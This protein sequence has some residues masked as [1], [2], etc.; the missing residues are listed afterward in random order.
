MGSYCCLD[1]SHSTFYDRMKAIKDMTQFFI[2]FHTCIEVIELA[3]SNILSI[4]SLPP[5][6]YLESGSTLYAAGDQHPNRRNLGVYDLILVRSGCLYLGEEEEQWELHAGDLVILLPD[7][8]HYAVQ[9]CREET[10]FYWLHFQAAADSPTHSGS[11]SH[12]IFLPKLAHVPYPDQA[13]QLFESLHL[14][15]TE[16]R[17]IALWREQ[18]L[19]IELMQLLDQSRAGQEQS[20]ARK[21][22]EQIESFIKIH[23]REPISNGRLSESL[24]FHYNYLT[25]CMKESHGVTPSE[26]LL[27]Y[28]LDQ[29]KRLLLTTRWPVSRIAEHVGFQ[30]PP[31]FTRRFSARFGI[32]PLQYRKQYTE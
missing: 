8:Y 10:Y 3:D 5:P 7:A 12:S 26:Y 11:I 18:S 28:R 22:A 19:F 31:Y 15:A 24:H 6:Y 14:L 13:Y 25:R 1:T 16:P 29:A 20:R 21:V 4:P 9:A 30:Y 32:S 2:R 23:Y 17:S 27:Q